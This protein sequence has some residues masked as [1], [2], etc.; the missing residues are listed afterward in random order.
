MSSS[1]RAKLSAMKTGSGAPPSAQPRVFLHVRLGEEPAPDGLFS[2]F[3]ARALMR[4]GVDFQ[5]PSIE[6]VLF[7]DTET[8]GL[9]GG[10]GTV[11]FLV[12]LGYVRDGLFQT[13]QYLMSDYPGEIDLLTKLAARMSAFDTLVT[14]N[15]RAFD[16]PLLETRR[17]MM[18]M[19]Q[20]P[21]LHHLDLL[22]PSRRLWKK[23][24][25][26]VK[27]SVLEEKVLRRARADDLPGSEA[28]RRFFEFLKCGDGRLLE[29]VIEHNR[30]DVRSMAEL[31]MELNDQYRAPRESQAP[32]D[33]IS[34]GKTLE[35]RG[36]KGEAIACYRMASLP[37][38]ATSIAALKGRRAEG[39][40]L[41]RMGILYLRMGEVQLA[42]RTFEKL[43]A[44][45]KA[46]TAPLIELAKICEHRLRDVDAALDWTERAMRTSADASE[47]K[48]LE[49]R[50]ARL[51]DKRKKFGG[52][53]HGI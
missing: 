25:G 17:T 21:P 24:L 22:A 3:D 36:E 18:R 51:I 38:P 46:G 49:R 16:M 11:A 37:R 45:D 1:L 44:R 12:G 32:E 30:Q 40:A 6:K 34:L 14:F 52:L 5:W 48:A 41:F 23:R 27:L 26:S 29:P 39:E 2:P 31:L 35:K 19:A 10:A 8:T 42:A 4:M 9:S 50:R 33:L 13:E 47:I 53:H 28:P 7:L 15:G 43:A 20:F